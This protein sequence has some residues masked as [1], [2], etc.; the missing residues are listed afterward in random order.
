MKILNN[1][2][3]IKKQKILN[4]F[5]DMIAYMLINKKLN[6]V[7]TESYFVIPKNIGLNSAHYFLM[8]IPNK[9]ELPQMHLI[10]P[11]IPRS[12]IPTFKTLSIFI[13]SVL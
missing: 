3:N 7:V 11:Q 2:I 12:I 10:N 13:K 8:K 1:S 6:P 9:R 4:A 5:N